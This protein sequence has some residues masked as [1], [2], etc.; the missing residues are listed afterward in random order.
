MDNRYINIIL[1]LLFFIPAGLTAQ[2]T[3]EDTTLNFTD[4]NGNKQG[5]W[6]KYY[7]NGQMRYRGFFIDDQPQDT[8][9]HYHPNGEIKAR[10]IFNDKGSSRAKLYYED[11]TLASYGNF[12]QEREKN[13]RWVFYY[14]SGDKESEVDY[15]DGIKNGEEINFFKNG[16]VMLVNHFQD[17]V[18]EG[19][20]I[21]YFHNGNIREKG[22]YHEGVRHGEFVYK[23]P[24]GQVDEKGIFENG[25]R[26]GEWKMR[27]NKGELKI[28]EYVNGERTD[29]DSLANEFQEKADY[30]KDHQEEIDD[31]E[32]FM[33]NPMKYFMRN[34]NR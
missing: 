27:N 28:V 21:Y 17:D 9:W 12:N 1:V 20:Y 26:V 11:G 14:P 32:D 16:H 6:I 29:R 23:L 34:R 13:G 4:I 5:R 33:R 25:K 22:F 18:K 2:E 7:D 30:A 10:Q 19:E 15:T 3:G 31:P 8:F 24:N